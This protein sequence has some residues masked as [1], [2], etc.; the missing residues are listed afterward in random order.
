MTVLMIRSM[1][2]TIHFCARERTFARPSKPIASHP[3]CASRARWA[4]C[5]SCSAPSTGIV[6]MISP[7]AGF[8]TGIVAADAPPLVSAVACWVTLAILLLARFLGVLL[9]YR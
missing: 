1:L 5:S 6:V 7:V 8:S 9:A 2:S 3:G 4:I